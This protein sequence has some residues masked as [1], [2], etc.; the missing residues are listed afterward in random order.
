M[1]SYS[2]FKKKAPF[3]FEL[4]ENLYEMLLW[5]AGALAKVTYTVNVTRYKGS[6][7]I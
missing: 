4:K 3:K 5:V 1:H 6:A 7:W 2:F